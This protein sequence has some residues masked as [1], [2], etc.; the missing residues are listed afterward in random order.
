MSWEVVAS[1]RLSPIQGSHG[2]GTG[3]GRQGLR[4][5]EKGRHIL[6]QSR[7]DRHAAAFLLFACVCRCSSWGN[8]NL[9][10]GRGATLPVQLQ[11]ACLGQTR[12]SQGRQGLRVMFDARRGAAWRLQ[13]HC[14]T[15]WSRVL[16]HQLRQGL[17]ISFHN[18]LAA[19]RGPRH[20]E[21]RRISQGFPGAWLTGAS[22]VVTVGRTRITQGRQGLRFMINTRRGAA[23]RLQLQCCTQLMQ[24][25]FHQSRQGL[26]VTLSGQRTLTRDLPG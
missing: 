9:R 18:Q 3:S 4:S 1:P 19:T 15:Q 25:R 20:C 7:L 17:R 10:C 26:R 11:H 12:S 6:S 24:V 8:N 16:S 13:L 14:F 5:R 22:L 23:R 2:C 21:H